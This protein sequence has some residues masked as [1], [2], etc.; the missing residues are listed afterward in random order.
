MTSAAAAL[1]LVVKLQ[2]RIAC[3]QLRLLER[4]GQ[5]VELLF[6]HSVAARGR[7][8]LCGPKLLLQRLLEA[9][10]QLGGEGVGLPEPPEEVGYLVL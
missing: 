9:P 4:R 1:L 3:L 7:R 6:G 5:K 10:G 8:G 2:R